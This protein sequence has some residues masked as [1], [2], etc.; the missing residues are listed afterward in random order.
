MDSYAADI[1]AIY[2]I[3]GSVEPDVA[4][5][6]VVLGQKQR[7][8]ATGT[9]FTYGFVN[10]EVA[11]AG[12][13]STPGAFP[14]GAFRPISGDARFDMRSTFDATKNESIGLAANVG[15]Q[16][17]VFV[18]NE[19]GTV[20]SAGTPVKSANGT[21]GVYS[22]TPAAADTAKV[23]GVAQFDIPTGKA[24]FILVEGVGRVVAGATV[25]AL[26]KIK[27]GVSSKVVDAST[28]E[29]TIGYAIAGG[30]SNALIDAYIMAPAFR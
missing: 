24:A 2:N 23:I 7:M 14:G 21:S 13:V 17:W 1:A 5:P 25:S 12:A 20:I 6:P 27:T 19:T 15:E 29:D 18:A 28:G 16:V 11:N 3:T 10:T 30:A 26:A 8:P 9:G 4:G 22:V